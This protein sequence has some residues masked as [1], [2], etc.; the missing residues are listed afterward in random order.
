MLKFT[1]NVSNGCKV[2]LLL[3]IVQSALAGV[4]DNTVNTE[5]PRISSSNELISTILNNCYDMNCLKS[6][7]LNY[8]NTYLNVNDRDARS[9]HDVDE[10]IYDRVARILKTKEFR[11]QLPETFFRKSEITFQ[12]GRGFDVKVSEDA[13]VEGICTHNKSLLDEIYWDTWH[14]FTA[15]KHKDDDI[16]KKLLLPALLLLKLKLKAILPIFVALIGLKAIKALILSKL[17]I[18]LVVGFIAYSLLKKPATP[19][20]PETSTTAA[21]ASSYDPSSWEPSASAGG[22][23]AR[24]WDPS[25]QNLAY[26]AYYSGS[27]TGSGSSASGSATSKPSYST[28]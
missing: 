9:M 2:V 10:Q 14:L 20:T 18:T 28:I 1:V 5:R 3:C 17:A 13:A 19:A 24:V 8:L 15:R 26:S 27:S 11:M 12:G 21:P 7:V 23:Y 6:N 25:A 22:P 4:V 16:K